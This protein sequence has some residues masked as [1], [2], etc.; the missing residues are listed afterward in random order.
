GRATR[1]S[2]LSEPLR[3]R[4]L[5]G[6]GMSSGFRVVVVADENHDGRLT[7]EEAARLVRKADT[8]GDGSV[9]FHDIDRLILSSFP[10]PFRSRVGAAREGPKPEPNGAARA[11]G[12]PAELDP[13][14]ETRAL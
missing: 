1:G 10:R 4:G 14:K 5:I 2:Q 3:A 13:R 9:D 12:N 11:S 8:D 6:N 7:P